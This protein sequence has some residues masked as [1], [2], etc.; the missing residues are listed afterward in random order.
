[1]NDLLDNVY[2]PDLKKRSIRESDAYKLLKDNNKDT[3][4]LEGYDNTENIEPIEFP[5]FNTQGDKDKFIEENAT[6]TASTAK[7]YLETFG[8]FLTDETEDLVTSLQLAAVNGADVAVNLMPLAYKMFEKAPIA[9]AMPKEFF[10][11]E[12]EEDV[13]RVAKHYSDNLGE[14]RKHLFEKQKDNGWVK[15]ILSLVVQDSAYSIPAFN[16][17]RKAGVPKY[18]AFF[19]SAA[20]GAIGVE[21][22]DRDGDKTY[23]A[24]FQKDVQEL[25]KLLNILPDTPADKIADE[26]HQALEYGSFGTA[27]PGIIDAF[28]FMKKYLPKFSTVTGS[29]AA[30]VG[31]TADNEAE[32]SPIKSILKAV[33]SAPMFKSAVVDAADNIPTVASGDQIFN[34][35]KNTSGVKESELKWMDLEG[36]LKGKNKV[37][38]DEVLE[39]INTNKIDVAEVTMSSSSKK[40]LPDDFRQTIDDYETR[41]RDSDLA[42]GVTPNYDVYKFKTTTYANANLVNRLGEETQASTR[43]NLSKEGMDVQELKGDFQSMNRNPLLQAMD[44]D[45]EI[46]GT[47]TSFKVLKSMLTPWMDD[48][49]GKYTGYVVD[50]KFPI[51]KGSLN[52]KDPD[53]D[54]FLISGTKN[55]VLVPEVSLDSI[56]EGNFTRIM[57]YEIDELELEKFNIEDDIRQFRLNNTDQSPVYEKYTSPG[58]TEYTELVFK[59]KNKEGTTPAILEGEFGTLGNNKVKSAQRTSVNYT[60]P[61]FN[62]MNEFAHVRFKT[63]TL[64]NGKKVLAVEEMQSDLLQAS[65]TE[66]FSSANRATMNAP[67]GDKVLK[68]FPFKNNWYEFTIKRLTRYA[69]DNGFDAIAIPK[70]SLAANRYGQKINKITSVEAVPSVGKTV[71]EDAYIIRIM[72]ENNE[73]F[74]EIKVSAGGPGELSLNQVFEQMSSLR[75]DIGDKNYSILQQ[76]YLEAVDTKQLVNNKIET[77]VTG[78]GKGKFELYDKTIPGY[79]KKYAKKWN[80]KVYDYR[81]SNPENPSIPVTVLELSDEM[82][83][84]VQSSSQPLFE[85]FGGVSL[86]TWGAK[87]VSDSMKNNTIS[88]T[89]N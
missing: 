32:G 64:D 35:I 69:A 18:P 31:M 53:Y 72:D 50:L 34:T 52:K 40:G 4:V 23:F 15:D 80:A 36:F 2:L 76:T 24:P 54:Y 6:S 84:G 5:V 14:Y 30:V 16:M 27:I 29:T 71:D 55:R 68:D 82:K 8:N 67:G 22:V 7:D 61:H 87:A 38:K 51:R 58:G 33:D 45:A 13:M 10:N 89:T 62:K 44:A 42:D 20:F 77:S 57:K 75:K 65:K 1:M 63:R 79:M 41:W 66:L 37:S 86:S 78:T 39:Y 21:N 46:F 26:V 9:M 17:M 88:Q 19:L 3:S 70:G 74:K 43:A 47:G 56:G 59:I 25:K 81:L 12:T 83:T 60:S 28:V 85:L 49:T 11:T 48:A 73:A